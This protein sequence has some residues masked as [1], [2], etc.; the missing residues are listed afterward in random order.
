MGYVHQQGEKGQPVY[1]GTSAQRNAVRFW[2][3]PYWDKDS[4]YFLSSTRLGSDNLL[5]T[6]IYHDTYKNGLDIYTDAGYT[7]HEPTSSY[8]DI[9][10]GA[11]IEW[12]N[13]SLDGHELSFAAHYKVDE[14]DDTGKFY[15]DVTTSLVVQDHI[16]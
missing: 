2:R 8:K 4:L 16:A 7:E 15:R 11:S 3:W 1:T 9:S 12:A 13:F 10:K 6:R 5:K 14:H